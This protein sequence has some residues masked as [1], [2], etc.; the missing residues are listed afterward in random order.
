MFPKKPEPLCEYKGKRLI[1][2]HEQPSIRRCVDSL[3]RDED[4]L[5]T[6]RFWSAFCFFLCVREVDDVAETTNKRWIEIALCVG[7]EDNWA[8]VTL[9]AFQEVTYLDVGVSVMAVL[10]LAPPA[11]QGIGFIEEEYPSAFLGCI[12]NSFQVLLRLSNLLTDEGKLTPGSPKGS[13]HLIAKKIGC[14]FPPQTR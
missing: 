3:I 6:D 4:G 2:P 1:E 9:H 11:E 8:A 12:E 14:A 5:R 7:H 10:N 13:R